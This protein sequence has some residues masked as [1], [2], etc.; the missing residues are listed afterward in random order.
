[1]KNRA[2]TLIELLVVIAIIAI[3][4]AML[5]P[6]LNKAKQKGMDVVCLNN[7][8]QLH[9]WA[10]IY[11]DDSDGYLPHNGADTA[12]HQANTYDHSYH[13][14]PDGLRWYKRAAFY[15]RGARSGT[16][17]HCPNTVSKVSPKQSGDRWGQTYAM[18]SYLGGDVNHFNEGKHTNARPPRNYTVSAESWL[19]ADGKIEI[20]NGEYR[21]VPGAIIGLPRGGQWSG[22]FFWE[23][24]HAV[25]SDFF[26]SGHANNTVS[27]AMINGSARLWSYGDVQS[28]YNAVSNQPGA[29]YWS[30]DQE[31]QGG[32]NMGN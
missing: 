16:S 9:V 11:S 19:F 5:L 1:M 7:V 15:D 29:T 12:T 18:S 23:P 17:F 13:S 2:F 32:R 4:A 14:N 20:V 31:F 24:N 8:R 22:P 28:H 26:G 21:P 3:L 6:A 30:W 27:L 25:Y 10:V